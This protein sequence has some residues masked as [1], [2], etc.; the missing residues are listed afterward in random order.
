M[1][2]FESPLEVLALEY[3]QGYKILCEETSNKR[4][5]GY[6]KE[7]PNLHL[8]G[9]FNDDFKLIWENGGN[10]CYVNICI[11][12]Y[13]MSC[14]VY[15]LKFSIISQLGVGDEVPCL[16]VHFVIST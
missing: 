10:E 2:T 14:F 7:F 8:H 11:I 16:L 12:Y 1:V 4:Q 13:N 6:N 9:F 5:H 15:S 3:G